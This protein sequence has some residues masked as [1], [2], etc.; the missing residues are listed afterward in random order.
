M[1]WLK[2]LLPKTKTDR[3]RCE[4]YAILALAYFRRS[5]KKNPN[6]QRFIVRI[7]ETGNSIE[8]K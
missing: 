4:E 2:K 1:K 7:I 6:E 5:L 8:I 3:E